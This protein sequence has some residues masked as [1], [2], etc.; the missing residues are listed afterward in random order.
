MP[1]APRGDLVE[2]ARFLHRFGEARAEVCAA[3]G[4]CAVLAGREAQFHPIG[5]EAARRCR[6]Q[7]GVAGQQIAEQEVE[8][9]S[10]AEQRR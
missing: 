9:S 7:A 1:M 8:P 4:G 6:V 2:A 10:R 5:I 3:V